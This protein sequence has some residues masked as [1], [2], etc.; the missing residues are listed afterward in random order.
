MARLNAENIMS[1]INLTNGGLVNIDGVEY[2]A[3]SNGKGGMDL[4]PRPSRKPL[5]LDKDSGNLTDDNGTVVGR[6]NFRSKMTSD[7][8][9]ELGTANVSIVI[10]DA[11]AS[12]YKLSVAKV[13]NTNKKEKPEWAG[14]A[15]IGAGRHE[16]ALFLTRDDA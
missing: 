3:Q 2:V 8:I 7:A 5:N 16:Y 9:P 10:A 14:G 13:A 4:V 12:G 15:T 6:V 1:T 11:Y